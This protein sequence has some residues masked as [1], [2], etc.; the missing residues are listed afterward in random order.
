[1]S[2]R[3]E[4]WSDRRIIEPWKTAAHLSRNVFFMLASES[5]TIEQFLSLLQQGERWIE[6]H[7]GRLIRHEPP[8]DAHGNVVRNVG[9]ALA[10]HLRKHPE[11][12]PCFELGLVVS[13]SPASVWCP[14]ISGFRLAESFAETDQLITETVPSLVIEVASTNDRRRG[15]AER[16]RQYQAWGVP[17]VWVFDP[18]AREVHVFGAS[19]PP[20]RF[21]DHETLVDAAQ[22]PGFALRV[23]DAFADPKWLPK[24]ASDS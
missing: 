23:A 24:L 18:S 20:Q 2:R 4:P 6:L 15:L 11:L 14:A 17:A 3:L 21:R 12:A 13:R 22:L 9:R 10:K 5:L 7:A 19:E 8:D 16:V 1:L